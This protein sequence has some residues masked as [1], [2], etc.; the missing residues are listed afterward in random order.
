MPYKLYFL[1]DTADILYF[2]SAAWGYIVA[3]V[4]G[5][6]I[7]VTCLHAILYKRSTHSTM[8]WVGVILLSPIVGS[9]FY[10]LFGVNRI[11]KK[12][13][14]LLANRKGIDPTTAPEEINT[15]VLQMA[16]PPEHKDLATLNNLVEKV[17][18]RPLVSGNHIAPLINGDEAF[19][20][21]LAAIRKAEKTIALETYIFDNDSA[22]QRFLQALR[23]AKERGVE[24]RVLLDAL[25]ARYSW[26]PIESQFRSENIPV[27]LFL[28]TR[29]P[30]HIPYANLRNHRKVLIVDGK[31]AFTGG[32]NIRVGNMLHESPSHPI[33]DL[34]FRL[35]GPITGQLQREFV[36]DWAFVTNEQLDGPDWFPPLEPHGDI[37]A[38]VIADGPDE[39]F[40]KLHWTISGAIASAR[41]SI[42]IVS[43]YFLPD[44]HILTAL[45][46]AAMRG[47]DVEILIPEK[48][49][50]AMVQWAS[51][52]HL[53]LMLAHG[54]K[55]YA[56]APPFDHSKLMIVDDV[57]VLLGSANMDPRSLKLNFELNVE[58][59]DVG[60]ATRLQ[61]HFVE[62]RD[63]SRLMTREELEARPLSIRIRDG[64]ARLFTPYL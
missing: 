30:W 16:L 15:Q 1:I 26:P 42:R 60:L 27:A 61:K 19:P 3:F 21:M 6:L 53:W 47:V 31:Q 14:K 57:W 48:N 12:A 41:S 11:R 35:E 32:M 52:D 2:L 37:F 45:N 50:L 13:A 9:M 25:G 24:V 33:Q 51:M 7:V 17:V 58:A 44:D 22:G 62:K 64:I 18:E 46:V 55:I 8:G 36:E 38:R 20:E 29:L 54:C 59:F 23:A 39:N 49:N 28:P 10:M 63:T 5:A 40:Q 43:P 34:H 4:V 56:S